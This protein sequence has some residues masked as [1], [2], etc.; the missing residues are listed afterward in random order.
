MDAGCGSTAWPA[1]VNTAGRPASSISSRAAPPTTWRVTTKGARP[2]NDSTLAAIAHALAGGDVG[3][4]LVAAR[5]ARGGDHDRPRLPPGLL[6][7]GCPG[8]A[9]VRR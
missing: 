2:P 3:E 5:R 6:H 8:G 4:H 9:A 1:T 7:G